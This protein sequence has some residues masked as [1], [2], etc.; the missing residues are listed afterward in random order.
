MS[1][2]ILVKAGRN[3]GKVALWERDENHPDGEVWVD[4][5]QPEPVSVYPTEAVRTKIAQGVLVEVKPEKK[6]APGA[7]EK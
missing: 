4:G 1:D 3:D 5:T 6:A 2:L 7:K